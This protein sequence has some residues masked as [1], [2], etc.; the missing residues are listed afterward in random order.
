MR[1]NCR[2]GRWAEMYAGKGYSWAGEG[3]DGVDFT[4][5]HVRYII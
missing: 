4:Y 5:V 2:I 3:E 1:E